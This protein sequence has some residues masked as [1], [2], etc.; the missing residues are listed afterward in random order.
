MYPAPLLASPRGAERAPR[1]EVG[2]TDLKGPGPG[3]RFF[4]HAVTRDP[5]T[6]E[7]VVEH[8]S[9]ISKIFCRAH[10]GQAGHVTSH[11]HP[12]IRLFFVDRRLRAPACQ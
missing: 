2:V 3:R 7:H 4:E 9:Q 10:E 11:R 6:G 12:D 5:R 1:S 8:R